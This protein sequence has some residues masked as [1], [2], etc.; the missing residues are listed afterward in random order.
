[1]RLNNILDRKAM[2]R[3]IESIAENLT[4]EN[5]W[6][7]SICQSVAADLG[8]SHSRLKSMMSTEQQIR[9]AMEIWRVARDAV[10]MLLPDKGPGHWIHLSKDFLGMTDKTTVEAG[11]SWSDLVRSLA[12]K[13]PDS[14]PDQENGAV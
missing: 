3:R 1:M 9:E 10:F 2:I 4:I 12:A 5:F 6:Q 11:D 14:D 8:L 7:W 13:T